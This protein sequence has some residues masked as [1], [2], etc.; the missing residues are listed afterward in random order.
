MG[1]LYTMEYYSAL[2]RNKNRSLEMWMDLESALQSKVSLPRVMY[3]KEETHRGFLV[4]PE[5]DVVELGL[6]FFLPH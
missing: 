6:E 5:S 3:Q 2:K 1:Y 4:P